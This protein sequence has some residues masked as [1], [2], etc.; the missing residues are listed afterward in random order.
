[1]DNLL[2]GLF[3]P[4]LTRLCSSYFLSL[5]DSYPNLYV[6]EVFDDFDVIWWRKRPSHSPF[7]IVGRIVIFR[8]LSI[9]PQSRGIRCFGYI[10]VVGHMT[11]LKEM[12]SILR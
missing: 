5:Y 10:V 11:A 7:A 9:Y 12:S 4:K 6:N 3:S 1:M 8:I 2:V